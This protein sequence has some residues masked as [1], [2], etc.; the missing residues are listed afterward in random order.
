MRSLSIPFHYLLLPSRG[1]PLFPLALFSASPPSCGSS[2]VFFPF[3]GPS[4]PSSSVMGW[5]SWGISLPIGFLHFRFG[6]SLFVFSA[7]WVSLPCVL[8][9]L[10]LLASLGYVPAFF[11]F[12]SFVTQSN[13]SSFA[14]GSSLRAESPLSVVSCLLFHSFASCP[15]LL[16]SFL[17]CSGFSHSFSSLCRFPSASSGLPCGSLYLSSLPVGIPFGACFICLLRF[18]GFL[19]FGVFPAPF[20]SSCQFLLFYYHTVAVRLSV[21]FNL[22]CF[23]SFC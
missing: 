2:S 22:L 15:L 12:P 21:S 18:C 17:F 5:F 1:F 7:C 23:L 9:M 3:G 6:S 8:H 16:L 11:C 10:L 20:F 19:L 14:T 4:P 13:L